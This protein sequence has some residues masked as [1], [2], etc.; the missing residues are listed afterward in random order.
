MAT[1]T[2]VNDNRV[3]GMQRFAN[4]PWLVTLDSTDDFETTLARLL[5]AIESSP[6]DVAFTVDHAAGAA[7]VGLDLPPNTLVVFGNPNL[8]T[9]LMQ[10]AP[11]AGIDLPLKILIWDDLAGMTHVTFTHLRHLDQRHHFRGQADVTKLIAG[12][13]ANLAAAAAG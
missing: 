1:G 9:P 10:A 8:G 12:A 4:K 2:D 6:A 5:A 7:R 13:V 3:H 11:S